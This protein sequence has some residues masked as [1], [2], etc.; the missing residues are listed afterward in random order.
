M[1]GKAS[2][3][4][5]A[6]VINAIASGNGAAFAVDLRVEAEVEILEDSREIKGFVGGTN[7]DST[8]IE[9]CVRNV[10]K[11]EGFLGDYG[12]VVKTETELPIAVGLSSS[13]AAANAT[14]LATC[15]ALDEELEPLDVIGVGIDSA[16]EAGTT[17]TGAFDDASASYFGGGVIT[18]NEE[19]TILGRFEIEEDMSVMIFLPSERSYTSDVDVD[20]IRLLGDVIDSL[21]EKALEGN[22]YGTL[23]V[24]GLLYSSVLGYDIWPALDALDVGARSA[25]LTGTGPA[26][27]ALVEEENIESVVEKWKKGAGD[28]IVTRSSEEGARIEDE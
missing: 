15:S 9:T 23:T 13:S 26:V 3:C 6:T 28:I 2:A 20:K 27:I 21:Q 8:L 11:R 5:S 25:G 7:E 10:L 16:F 12:A 24:N 14:V 1:K 17:V 18:D 4:G 19:R 22:I